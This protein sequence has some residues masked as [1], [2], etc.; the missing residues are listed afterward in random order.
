MHSL[1]I[2]LSHLTEPKV[3]LSSDT[4]THIHFLLISD[5]DLRMAYFQVL[6]IELLMNKVLLKVRAKS[7]TKMDL[8][9]Y[10]GS[11][12]LSLFA[13]HT[14][15]RTTVEGKYDDHLIDSNVCLG[16]NFIALKSFL[17]F[18]FLFFPSLQK[19]VNLFSLLWLLGVS[20]SINYRRSL[21]FQN[22]L[23]SLWN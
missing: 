16:A 2:L 18:S 19:V 1:S 8:H 21:N 5:V 12:G 7:L 20:F 13:R 15:T 17:F 22:A 9:P 6:I 11:H 23:K 4:P 10:M 14:H 3:I